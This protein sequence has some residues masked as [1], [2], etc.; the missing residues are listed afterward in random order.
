M[1]LSPRSLLPRRGRLLKGREHAGMLEPRPDVVGID[2]LRPL[3][4]CEGLGPLAL[5]APQREQEPQAAEM[6]GIDLNRVL[7]IGRGE[8]GVDFEFPLGAEHE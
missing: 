6:L 4:E 5:L 7:Q 1:L 8:G 2:G 3:G